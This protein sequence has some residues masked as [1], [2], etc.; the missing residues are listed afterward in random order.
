VVWNRLSPE[1]RSIV[2][3]DLVGESVVARA[4]EVACGEIH[5]EHLLVAV[6]LESQSGEADLTSAA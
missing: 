4:A 6:A 3:R 2:E 1:V 5:L